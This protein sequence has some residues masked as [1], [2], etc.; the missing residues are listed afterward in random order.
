MSR[1]GLLLA[2][3]LPLIL[4][5][6]SGSEDAGRGLY[7]KFCASCHGTNLEGQPDWIQRL[8]SGRLPAPPHNADGH[9]WHHSDEQLLI[10]IRDGLEAI[11]P[12]YE[13]DMPTF[14]DVL[15]DEEI[16]DILEYIKSTWPKR[17]RD[18]QQARSLPS[19]D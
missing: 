10:M 17:E 11:A 8:P 16:M 4:A 9:T 13:T 18:Y 5:A 15:S 6:C 14:A 1:A 7:T 19:K 12:G 2:F 3:V